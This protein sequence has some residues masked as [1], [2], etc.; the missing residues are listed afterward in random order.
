MPENAE[1]RREKLK[2]EVGTGGE[3]EKLKPEMLKR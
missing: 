2:A 3:A 1:G